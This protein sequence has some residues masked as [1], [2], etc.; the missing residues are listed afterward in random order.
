MTQQYTP[1]LPADEPI[2]RLIR[3]SVTAYLPRYIIWL[4]AVIFLYHM[5]TLGETA[6]EILL[7]LIGSLIVF[8]G[9]EAWLLGEPFYWFIALRKRWYLTPYR[10]HLGT[11]KVQEVIDLYDVDSIKIWMVWGIRVYCDD[12]IVHKLDYIWNP[13]DIRSLIL[14]ARDQME[15]LE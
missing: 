5:G 15:R 12:G 2:I 10:I 3:P 4:I 7:K 8:L 1:E 11:P 14:N 9:I 13:W 6:P